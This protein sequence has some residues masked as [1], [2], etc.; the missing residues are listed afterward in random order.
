VYPAWRVLWDAQREDWMLT[1]RPSRP[2]CHELFDW[3]L[4]LIE[5]GPPAEA[6]PV[7][8]SVSTLLFDIENAR[9]SVAFLVWPG[10]PKTI[11][12]VEIVSY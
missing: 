12:F 9:A 5:D 7:P 2:Q 4:D 11:G 1:F 10:A 6:T 8:G 3:V